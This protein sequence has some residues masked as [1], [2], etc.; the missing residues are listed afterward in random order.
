MMAALRGRRMKAFLY[1]NGTLFKHF[2]PEQIC[3]WNINSVV[4][5]ID[6][7]D[8]TSFEKQR[9][10]GK[11]SEIRNDAFGFA[12]HECKTKPVFE[13]RHVI[14]P[15]ESSADLRAF[16]RDW[17]QLADTVKFNYLLPLR[18]HGAAVPS[19]VRWRDIRR[20][21]Y[22]RWDG[23]L[24]LCAGQDRQHPPQWLG[25][26]TKN[27]IS[28]LWFD[29]RLKDLRVAHDRREPNPPMWCNNCSFR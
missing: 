9:K 13:V 23:R 8:A 3:E 12:G 2:T 22:I 15:N 26:A 5:S 18:P 19:G 29:V 17:L 10:G 28:E 11:Y 20:E 4:L 24:L 16:K 6:G 7:L 14:L 25:D 27:S 1:T 21:I